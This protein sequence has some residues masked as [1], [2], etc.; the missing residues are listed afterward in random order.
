MKMMIYAAPKIREH[1]YFSR[2][3]FFF[4]NFFFLKI[5][6]KNKKKKSSWR[7]KKILQELGFALQEE[8]QQILI[9]AIS[10]LECLTGDLHG[11][12]QVEVTPDIDLDSISFMCFRSYN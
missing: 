9:D 6:K 7:K 11:I 4:L 2:N 3:F 12:L 1:L 5:K 10:S 8:W